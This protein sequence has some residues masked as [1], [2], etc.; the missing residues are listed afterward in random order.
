MPKMNVNAFLQ[1]DYENEPPSS[2][3]N[4]AKTNPIQ[5]QFKPNQHYVTGIY[6]LGLR[7]EALIEIGL[8]IKNKANIENLFAISLAN[9]TIGHICDCQG[10]EEVG[11]EPGHR[12]NLAEGTRRDP[13]RTC[14]ERH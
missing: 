12:T 2:P 14:P 6:F 9:N 3:K 1:K 13:C 10:Y 8:E 7:G 11:F 5:T 4:K